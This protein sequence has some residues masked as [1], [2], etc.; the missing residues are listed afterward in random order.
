MKI[1]NVSNKPYEWTFDSANYGPIMPGQIVDLP[2][3][4]A[5]HAI[6]RSEERKYDEFD[7]EVI[8]FRVQAVAA[9]DKSKLVKIV[10]YECPFSATGQ[11][12][13]TRF[14]SMDALRAHMETH[15]ASTPVDPVMASQGV[16]KTAPPTSR[17]T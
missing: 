16:Q 17:R 15:W 9:V 10:T 13:D 2:S 14:E 12:S 4:V 7:E 6:R 11:C 1:I 8:S 3:E 5:H